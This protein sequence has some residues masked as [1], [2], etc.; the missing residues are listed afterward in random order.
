ML[1]FL[2]IAFGT[3]QAIHQQAD[4]QQRPLAIITGG[5]RGIGFGIASV[6]AGQ[7]YDLI[8][9]YNTNVDA[10]ETSKSR[11]LDSHPTCHIECVGGDMTLVSTRD[12]IFACLDTKFKDNIGDAS[13]SPL[14]VLVH[15]AGQYIGITSQ[16]SDGLN[17]GAIAFGDGSLIRKDEDGVERPDFSSIQYYQRLYGEAWIDLCERCLQRMNSR[18]GGSIVGISSPGVH[19]SLY[20]PDRFYSAPGCG[21]TIMEYSMRIFAK[22]AAERNI[23]V[24]IVVP[25]IVQTEAWDSMEKYRQDGESTEVMLKRLVEYLVPLKRVQQPTDIGEVIAFLCS[26]SGRFITG[27]TLP[28]DGGQHIR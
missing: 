25:G 13:S 27:L 5:T 23:N 1:C 7:G 9:T 20:R 28:A 11:L 22:V 24:N 8:L 15:N 19:P 26:P 16:N 6:L 14:Q 2:Q 10:A 3:V 21:K 17:E 12:K 18:H 4:S